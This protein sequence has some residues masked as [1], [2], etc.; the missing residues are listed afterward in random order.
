MDGD[1][2]YL[3]L[4]SNS[5]MK[6]FPNNTTTQYTTQLSREIR[7]SG[8]WHVGLLEIHIPS[9]ILHFKPKDT[10]FYVCLN[11]SRLD[12]Y[13]FPAG[14]Y[15]SI[16]ELALAVNKDLKHMIL[17]PTEKMLGFYTLERTCE[18]KDIEHMVFFSDKIRRVFGFETLTNFLNLGR[19]VGIAVPTKPV[20]ADRPASLSRAIPNQLYVYTDLCT[21]YTV[22]DVQAPLLRVVTF[23]T[24][25]YKIG[26]TM[27]KQFTPINYIPLL[28][29]SF[30]SI[31]IDIK[32]EHGD[33][34]PFEF[35]TLT[36]TLHFK[37]FRG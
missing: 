25:N 1:D 5:S 15:N 6:Y 16:E 36:V 11:E 10:A 21:P 4:P 31:I 18:C 32:D 24:N 12:R 34:I 33:R 19:R 30:H 23:D 17:K 28:N 13:T 29:N 7:L 3:V 20:R 37:R 8:D 22:G 35:G 14:V 2:F 27:V 9:T 26:P